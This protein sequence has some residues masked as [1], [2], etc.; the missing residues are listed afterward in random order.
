MSDVIVVPGGEDAFGHRVPDFVVGN[1][2]TVFEWCMVYSG[3]HPGFAP[4]DATV[5]DRRQRLLSLGAIGPNISGPVLELT[6]LET[7]WDDRARHRIANAAFQELAEAIQT[8]RL[9]LR[10]VYLDDRPGEL[11]LTLCVI[12]K[13]PV[14]SIARR[15]RDY[16]QCIGALLARADAPEQQ[17]PAQQNTKRMAVKHWITGRYPKGVPAGVT[18]KALA[19]D[20]EREMHIIVS[21]RT[22]RRALGRR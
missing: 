21:E 20:I 10:R 3:R 12:G 15:R 11:D 6:T 7:H 9:E 2:H 1:E 18:A 16:G 13:G 5:A 17:P 8:G 14:L 19:R 4:K 22:V